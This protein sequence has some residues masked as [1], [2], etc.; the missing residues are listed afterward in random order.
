M[1]RLAVLT[2]IG[3][4]ACGALPASRRALDYDP[5]Y[6]R[7][8]WWS[9]EENSGPPTWSTGVCKSGKQQSPIDLCGAQG[10]GQTGSAIGDA[11][12][13]VEKHCRRR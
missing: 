1:L 4:A 3:V 5:S 10:L 9:N 6:E 13:F 8:S 12:D 2:L 11:V 7:C